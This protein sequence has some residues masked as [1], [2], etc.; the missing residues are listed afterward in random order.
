MQLLV[1][2]F[3]LADIVSTAPIVRFEILKL[4]HTV[5]QSCHVQCSVEDRC[6]NPTH[7]KTEHGRK[8]NIEIEVTSKA[9]LHS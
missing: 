1:H 3:S 5:C 2:G 8:G 9:C 6:M 7:R 4:F